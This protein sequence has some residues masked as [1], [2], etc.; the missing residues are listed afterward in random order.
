VCAA[1]AE[2]PSKPFFKTLVSNIQLA[3]INVYLNL[4]GSFEPAITMLVSLAFPAKIKTVFAGLFACYKKETAVG[5]GGDVAK[6]AKHTT[7]IF[8]EMIRAYAGQ[9]L[10]TPYEFPS[11]HQSIREPIDYYKMGN[12]YVGSMIDYTRSVMGNAHLWDDIQ[13]QVDAGENVVFL[14]NHQSEADAAFIPLL[15]MKSH[16]GLGEKVT[17]IAGDRV[18]GDLMSKPFSMG[19]NLLNIHS[20]KHMANDDNATRSQ[21]MRKNIATLKAMEALMKEGG[22]MIWIAPSGGRDRRQ[23][24]GSLKP[25]PFDP[26]AIEMMKKFGF[27]KGVKK[28]H[29][30]P[31]AMVTYDVMPPPISVG[32]GLGEERIV[33]YTGCGISLGEEIDVENGD[34]AK[35]VA[36]DDR[37][38]ALATYVYNV[39][40]AEYDNIKGCMGTGEAFECPANC[41]RPWYD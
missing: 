25:D 11:Y 38:Q 8:R 5:M 18:T 21:K 6:A 19:R 17:Y 37:K 31:M 33:N 26:D 27:K 35:G 32:G 39:V 2:A 34:W 24:D 9:I 22:A 13:R 7:L 4:F 14:A 20:K 10:G 1:A 15:T 30:Y 36:D 28:T 23:D 29:F 12:D 3:I 41:T 40:A 16:P